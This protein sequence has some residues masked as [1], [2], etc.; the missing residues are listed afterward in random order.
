MRAITI[1]TTPTAT[2]SEALREQLAQRQAA[3]ADA[4]RA[5]ASAQIVFDT[6]GDDESMRLLRRARDA[7]QDA[8][9]HV[10]RLERLVAAAEAE[11][12]AA[13]RAKLERRLFEVQSE[14][15][16]DPKC[17]QLDSAAVDA[18]VAAAEALLAVRNHQ[19]VRSEK[20]REVTSLALELGQ[21]D[22]Y[23]FSP[24]DLE[25]NIV[26]IGEQVRARAAG[27]PSSDAMCRYL[28]ALASIRPH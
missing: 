26:V 21:P 22:P 6:A 19:V 23:Q 5:V 27:L 11:E 20:R 2:S 10:A 13:H 4:K 12:A 9:E 18:F 1:N 3:H 25:P 7:E 8:S 16:G 15:A 14:L 17:K 28:W 24:E